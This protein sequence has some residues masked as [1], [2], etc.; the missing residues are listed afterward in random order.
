MKTFLPN[1]LL[2][3]FSHGRVRPGSDWPGAVP[4]L[5]VIGRCPRTQEVTAWFPQCLPVRTG[6]C[7]ELWSIVHT[8]TTMWRTQSLCAWVS[9]RVCAPT[10]LCVNVWGS[11]AVCPYFCLFLCGSLSV[12]VFVCLSQ[13]LGWG[14]GR[15]F[16]LGFWVEWCGEDVRDKVKGQ[17]C[18]K[19]WS[20]SVHF[21]WQG[22]Q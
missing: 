2:L 18:R 6:N 4:Y 10:C 20:H 22:W 12:C 5:M 16:G 9:L 17:K 7:V 21:M 14:Q 13:C 19:C 1:L 15:L 8:P 11:W 3:V